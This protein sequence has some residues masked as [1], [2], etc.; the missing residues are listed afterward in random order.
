MKNGDDPAAGYHWCDMH[1]PDRRFAYGAGDGNRTR[2]YSL[3]ESRFTTKLHP[4]ILRFYEY[5]HACDTGV[6]QIHV[7]EAYRFVGNFSSGFDHPE[8]FSVFSFS[9]DN[10]GF[11]FRKD[12]ASNCVNIFPYTL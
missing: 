9:S 12:S 10:R 4:H 11:R 5:G 2:N 8:E 3:E 7:A 6:F 1:Q